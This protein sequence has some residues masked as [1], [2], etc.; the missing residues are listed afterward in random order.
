M[1]VPTKSLIAQNTETMKHVMLR[2]SSAEKI[3]K[4]PKSARAPDLPRE[5]HRKKSSIFTGPW[6][7]NPTHNSNKSCLKRQIHISLQNCFVQRRTPWSC[8]VD[9]QQTWITH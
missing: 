4:S 5:G 8:S 6:P 3:I 7:L 1:S 9:K 2:S